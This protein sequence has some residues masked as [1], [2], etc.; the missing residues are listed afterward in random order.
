MNRPEH[1]PV[2]LPTVLAVLEPQNGDSVLDVTLGLGGHAEAFLH[3]IGD[4]GHLTALDA[5]MVNLA[6]A[7][8][9]LEA[10]RNQTTFIHANF[11]ELPELGI[12]PFNIVFGDL[13]VSSPHFDDPERGFSF[14]FDGPLDLRYDRTKGATA[15]DL[16]HASDEDDVIRWLKEYG[17]L[18]KEAT[19]IGREIAGKR[20]DTTTELRSVIERLFGFRAKRILP[21]VFQALRIVVNDEMGVLRVFLD[22]GLRLLKPGGRMGILSYHSLEDRMVKQVFRSVCEPVKDELTG[23]ITVEAPFELI[24]KGAIQASEEEQEQNPRSR[25]VRFRAVRKR[26]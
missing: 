15:A 19:R 23:Q 2:L 17:E 7:G 25:S 16:I 18:W 14:R 11:G 13:G 22:E 9:R 10:F 3:A 24:T 12:G 1:I 8:E 20:L 4:S 21:Q 26:M 6:L 5:D